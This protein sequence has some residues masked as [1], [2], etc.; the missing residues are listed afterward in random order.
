MPRKYAVLIAA[1]VVLIGCGKDKEQAKEAEA[2]TTVMVESAVFGAIDHVI[3]A[4]AVLY[5]INQ[6]NVTSKISAP[7][8]KVLVNRGDHVAAGKVLLGP[9][10]NDLAAGAAGS[11]AQYEEAHGPDP[12]TNPLDPLHC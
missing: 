1:L 8:K 4:D 6:A 7:V 2:P 5:P 9:G 11:K 3:A 10:D 12:N